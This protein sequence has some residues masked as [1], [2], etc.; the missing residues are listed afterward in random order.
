MTSSS[1]RLLVAGAAVAALA[2]AGLGTYLITDGRAKESRKAVKGPPPV[3]VTIA[4]VTLETVP[5]GLQAIGN[6][7]AYSTVA[8]KARVD[9][10]I[11]TVSV[12]DGDPVKKGDLLFRIDPRPYA[13]AL[14]QAAANALRDTAARD[15]AR[16][17]ERRYQ[18]LLDKN[19]VSKE[20]YAQ[21]R[22]NAETAEAT[23]GASQAALENARLNIEYCTIVSPLDGFIGKVLLQTGNLVKANDI[24]PLLVINQ[25]RPIY[26]N[27]AVPEQNLPEVRKNMASGPLRVEVLSPDPGAAPIVGRLIFVDNAV[28]PSTGTIRLRGEF[29]NV[30]AALWPGQFVNVSLRF[31]EQANALVIPTQAVQTGPEG[32]YVYVVSE[33]L[34]A[35]V[36]R[37]KVQRSDGE[38]TVV[39][40]GLAKGERVVLRGQLRLGP[41][42]RV[43]I[44]KPAAGAS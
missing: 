32:Q 25:V 44:G 9:G 35:D 20:A 15:Q 22:T 21:I 27:F 2:A 42:T 8:I 41:K 13:A 6:V 23:A 3:A 29:D 26:V 18:E 37:I 4:T 39:A 43:Q 31:Y 12:R 38:R 5:I 24:N 10:Q 40:D 11:N 36:R 14:R 28:D 30:D 1:R 33:E 7:E 16:S 17:Q 34:V 19:F